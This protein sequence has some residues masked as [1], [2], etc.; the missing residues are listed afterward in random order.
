MKKNTAI[1]LAF[2]LAGLFMMAFVTSAAAGASQQD[3]LV[4]H[5][6]Y[7]ATIAGCTSCHTPL[8][9]EYQNPQTLTL[10]QIQTIA[11]NETQ[12]TDRAKLLAGGRAFDLGPAGVVFTRNITPDAETGIGSWTDDQIKLA[13][14]TGI[15]NEGKLLFPVMPYHVYNGM[16]DADLEAVVAYLHSVSAVNNPVPD[17]TVSTEGMPAPPFQTGITVPEAS[18]QAARGAYLVNSVMGCTDCHTPVDPATGAP[19]MDK[20]LAGRQPYEGPWGIVYGGN[21]TPDDTTG[22][23]TWTDE[24]VKRAILAG[25]GKDGRRLILMP[26]FAYS[27]MTPEDADAVVFYLK[28]VL[29]AVNNEVPAASLNE[30]FMVM[31]PEA[32]NQ[33]PAGNIVTSPIIL[34]VVGIAVILLVSFIANYLRN[35]S[36]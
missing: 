36:T 27:A 32:Q 8:K 18:D 1:S 11:F 4:A 28:N 25:V 9:A 22:I 33:S 17:R 10:E 35:K 16:A 14:K 24:E 2:V 20:Y 13:I 6:K 34:A 23:G 15:D 29:S 26:W 21:I 7:I 5:G 12:A 3:D 30:G 31:A 19:Q